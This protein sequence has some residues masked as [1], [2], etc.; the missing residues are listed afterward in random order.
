MQR[1]TLERLAAARLALLIQI[2][3][4]A[5]L[6]I[7]EKPRSPISEPGNELAYIQA[8]QMP[9]MTA[10]SLVR[11]STR[12][13]HDRKFEA[14]SIAPDI[15]QQAGETVVPSS[16]PLESP[17]FDWE[18]SMRNT[19]R[20]FVDDQA[21]LE[22]QGPTLNSTPQVLVLPNTSKQP[23]RAGDTEHREGG[24]VITWL[25]ELCYHAADPLVATKVVCKVRSLSERRSEEL[26]EALETAVKPK[27]LTRPLPRP[28]PPPSS[29][30]S[31]L[32]AQPDVTIDQ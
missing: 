17:A 18:G 9:A 2:A 29:I 24:V 30:G 6:A 8:I 15:S 31:A 5:F 4:V 26:A 27:Y 22:E 11:G 1:T 3:A 21:V 10:H 12:P 23:H 25:T 16:L 7:V 19:V 20:Q 14:K 32:R 13:T 28:P